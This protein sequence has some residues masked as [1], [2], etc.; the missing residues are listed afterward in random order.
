[1]PRRWTSTSSDLTALQLS[2]RP[3]SSVL[4]IAACPVGIVCLGQST[5][6]ECKRHAAQCLVCVLRRR[7]SCA[8]VAAERAAAHD[9]SSVQTRR[10]AFV[11]VG[12]ARR[13]RFLR[14]AAKNVTHAF[15]RRALPN[16]KR[17]L[18]RILLVNSCENVV[19][20]LNNIVRIKESRIFFE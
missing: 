19:C 2:L 14:E 4:A 8:R 11:K 13:K 15:A 1:M 16:E 5:F 10:T 12:G 3:K 20:I 9:C 17:L 7:R 18:K 6:R